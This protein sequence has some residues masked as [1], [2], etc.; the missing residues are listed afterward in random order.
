MLHTY[1]I[2]IRP[3]GAHLFVHNNVNVV[4]AHCHVAESTSRESEQ[5][6][7]HISQ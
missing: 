5:C 6:L 4:E 1:T 2:Y 7:W 3:V